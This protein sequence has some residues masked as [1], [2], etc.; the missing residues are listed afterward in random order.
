MFLRVPATLV[1]SFVTSM[2]RACMYAWW[3]RCLSPALPAPAPAAHYTYTA[4]QA[5]ALITYAAAY[6]V[7]GRFPPHSLTACPNSNLNSN[8]TAA[9]ILYLTRCSQRMLG[10][11]LPFPCPDTTLTEL[12]EMLHTQTQ[13]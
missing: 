7:G 9:P 12:L 10:A 11:T 1:L 13:T 3:A 2:L 5:R 6:S 8:I 4:R